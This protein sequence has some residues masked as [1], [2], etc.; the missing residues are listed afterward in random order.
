MR[1]AL[2]SLVRAKPALF[3]AVVVA[4]VVLSA[5]L[6]PVIA[7]YDP[8]A[9]DLSRRLSPPTW[10]FAAGQYF[11]G[12]DVLGR[13]LLS[14]IIYGS[15]ISLIVGICSVAVAGGIGVLVGLISGYYGGRVDSLIMRIV[16]I[17][18]AV[19]VLVLAIAVVAVLG[20]SL[21]NI[22]LVLGMTAWVTYGRVVRGH[23][24]SICEAAYIES[25]RSIGAG[26][27]RIMFRHVLP[28]VGTSIIVVATLEVARMITA[29]A[30]LS[31]LGLGVQPPTPSWGGMVAEGK[32]VLSIAWW[33]S[34]FPGLAILLTVL[35]VNLLGDWLREALDP[36]QRGVE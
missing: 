13:D 21:R 3:G 26:N 27:L 34:A 33:L 8:T 14:R 29:E 24:L 17:Q 35:G 36:R 30:A 7:P 31:F 25:A 10:S 20:P 2:R 12:G 28:N 6:A 22:I 32:D 18:M 16:D 23:V 19:P 15:Q 4:L 11:L 5:I 1:K 9:Q